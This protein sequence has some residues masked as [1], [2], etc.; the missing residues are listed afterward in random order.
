V[1]YALPLT[2]S[3]DGLR[4]AFM[5]GESLFRSGVVQTD[6]VALLVFIVIMVP[7]SLKVFEWAY[8]RSRR[9]GTLGQY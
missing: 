8:R 5:N 2:Y 3:L 9:Q 1:G 6:L 4:R 7:L